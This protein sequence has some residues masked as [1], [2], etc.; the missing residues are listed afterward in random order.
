[1][2][3]LLRSETGTRMVTQTV[4][5]TVTRSAGS[6]AQPY[7][8]GSHEGEV[9]L[10]SPNDHEAH[11]KSTLNRRGSVLSARRDIPRISSQLPPDGM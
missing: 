5:R 4:T 11:C 7:L 2:V 3:V 10:F 1:M 6:R 8:L 9:V